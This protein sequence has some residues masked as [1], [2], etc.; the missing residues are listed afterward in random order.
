MVEFLSDYV[1]GELAAELRRAIDEHGGQ[2]PPCRAFV[3]TLKATVE[4][5]R[6]LPREPLEPKTIRSLA[7]ALR[8]ARK[9]S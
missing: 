7:D 4:A 2:C 9:T 5:V 3:N 8:Q 1:D 6:R